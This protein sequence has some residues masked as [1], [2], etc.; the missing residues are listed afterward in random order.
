MIEH[1]SKFAL[2]A[3]LWLSMWLIGASGLVD[4]EADGLA[5]IEQVITSNT[6]R[7]FQVR[8]LRE[9]SYPLSRQIDLRH[10]GGFARQHQVGDTD[11]CHEVPK[12]VQLSL[13]LP[14]T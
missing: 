2:I 10:T 12:H 11:R 7:L 13:P 1:I 3:V 4:M 5:K 8:R 14:D 9:F 6:R